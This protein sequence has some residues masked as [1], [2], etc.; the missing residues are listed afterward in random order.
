MKKSQSIIRTNLRAALPAICAVALLLIFWQGLS[1]SGLVPAYMLPSPV[2]VVQALV[3]ERALLWEHATIT[4]K[5]AAIG[6]VVGVVIGVAF[7]A[8]MDS[9]EMLYRAFYPILVMTQTIPSVAIAPLLVLWF[10]Y[11]MTPK[12]I[13]VVLATFFP[14]TVGVLEGFRSTDRDTIALLRSMGAGRWKIF[15]YLKVPS[16]LPQFFSGLRIA[17]AYSVVG[18]VISEWLGGFG[19]LGVY[20]TRVKKAFAYDKM[21]AVILLISV[22]SLLLMRL[23]DA[24]ERVG[25]PY[26]F[27]NQSP[28]ERKE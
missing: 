27:L 24:A 14:V 22:L 12:V 15:R 13:L 19:G 7:A 26:R 23:V 1:M 2:D 11:E 3:G 21:F 10:G 25:M 17:A 8:L 18:A 4:L 16:A 5:E 9:F 28:D 20:M 6:L